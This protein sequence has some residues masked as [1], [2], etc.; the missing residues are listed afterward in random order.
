MWGAVIGAG[1]NLA[2]GLIGYSQQQKELGRQKEESQRLAAEAKTAAEKA[3]AG[4]QDYGVGRGARQE[5]R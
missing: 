3:R 1:V 2:S 4:I 5:V